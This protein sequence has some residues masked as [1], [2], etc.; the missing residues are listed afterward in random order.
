LPDST[1]ESGLG[2]AF[3]GSTRFNEIGAFDVP[4]KKVII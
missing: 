2:K 3:T 4:E 1:E